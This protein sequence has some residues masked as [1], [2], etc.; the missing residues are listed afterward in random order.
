MVERLA[1]ELLSN[2]LIEAYDVEALG[3]ASSTVAAAGAAGAGSGESVPSP[4]ATPEGAS[5]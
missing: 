1:A 5:T 4:I 3:A 2:P